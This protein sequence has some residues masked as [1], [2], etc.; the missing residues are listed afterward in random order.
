MSDVSI[1][2]FNI[3]KLIERQFCLLIGIKI[4]F[5]SVNNIVLIEKENKEP[6][7]ISIYKQ[8]RKEEENESRDFTAG[9]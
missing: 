4:L 1:L 5:L 3:V 9:T 6:K 7:K 2:C 8:L